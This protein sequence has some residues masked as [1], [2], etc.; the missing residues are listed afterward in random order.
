M[1]PPFRQMLV[2]IGF[3]SVMVIQSEA[4]RVFENLENERS[5]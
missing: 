4:N 5:A 1:M 2:A 3:V